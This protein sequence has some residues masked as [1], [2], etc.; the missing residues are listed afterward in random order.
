[1]AAVTTTITPTQSV[2]SLAGFREP[3][4]ENS[5]LARGLLSL[6]SQDD[7][8][9]AVGAGDNQF[10]QANINLPPNFAYVL[11]D[12]VI[13]IKMNAA[14]TINWGNNAELSMFNGVAGGTRTQDI[15]IGLFSNGVAHVATSNRELKIY[16][17]WHIPTV[18]VKP[19]NGMEQVSLNLQ[20]FNET[21][22]DAAA[23]IDLWGSFLQYDIN[24][25]HNV[26]VNSP[27]PTR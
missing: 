13:S 6:V 18:P 15:P 11:L 24:Q 4:A 3:A 7:A 21:A 14:G 9:A 1:M 22:N 17:P 19:A 10:L 23:T 8:I 16:K 5:Y 27:I 20:F 25:V 12:F 2:F 26:G